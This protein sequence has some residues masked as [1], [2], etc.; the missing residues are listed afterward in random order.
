MRIEIK[1]K[2]ILLILLG[3]AI[4]GFGL[5]FF[6]VPAKIAAGG[7]SGIATVLYHL[8]NL[9]VG[10]MVFVINIPIFILGLM[11]FNWRFLL[12]SIIGTAALSFSAQIFEA[13]FFQSFLPLSQ[14]IFLCSV[15][16]GA[17]YGA[18]LGLVILAGGTTGGTDIVSLVLKKKFPNLSVGQ[19]IIAIDGFI[20]SVAGIA[21]K[22]IETLLYSA[23]LL[24]VS[25]YVLDT[26]LA[27]V[28]FAKIAY[29]I[30]EKND[31]ISKAISEKI[32]R[33]STSL[34]AHSYYSGK[35]RDV[36]MC[37]MRKYQVPPL[38]ELVTEIDPSAF[39]IVTDAKEVIGEGF[40][41]DLNSKVK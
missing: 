38:K 34:N 24:F 1:L 8:F 33:G 39:V 14:D 32:R 41:Y 35:S 3:G 11:E 2:N 18:G 22:S 37:V 30:S 40:R 6:L 36:L 25:S 20:I 27:G 7:V 21:F 10:I 12:T 15:L 28:D 31:E 9:P 29:I 4:M 5:E 23:V 19:L 17:I 26:I 16:G 13:D